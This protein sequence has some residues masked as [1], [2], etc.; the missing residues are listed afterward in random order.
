MADYNISLGVVVETGNIQ[1]Q[2]N[3]IGRNLTPIEID[4]RLNDG[5]ILNQI[6]NIR[7]QLQEL[8]NIRINI[9]AGNIGGIGNIG[10]VGNVARNINNS[11]SQITTSANNASNTIQRLRQ[12]LAS[13][14]F[15]N[16]SINMVTQHLEQMSLAITNV[17]SRI[18]NNDLRLNI[19][20][21]D[22]LGRTVTIL[23]QV[24]LAT[25]E[26]TNIGKNI[27]QSFGRS[28][29]EASQIN[30]A[31]REMKSLIGQISNTQIETNK[32]RAA[33]Q[34]VGALEIK[35]AAL[36]ARY[37]ELEANFAGGFDHN[38]TRNI[39]NEWE[40]VSHNINVA[41]EAITNVRSNLANGVRINFGNYDNQIILLENRFNALANK[42][43][44]VRTA[45]DSV[46]QALTTLR[47]ADGNENVIAAYDRYIEVLRT[48]QT[49]LAKLELI[50]RGSN[51]SDQFVAAK[52]AAMRR[53]NSLF[54]E[55]S[56]AAKKYGAYAQQLRRE[57]ENCGN[58]QGVQNVT[59]KIN[60]LGTEIKNTNIQTQTLGERLKN[61][62]SKYSSY[63][64][65]ATVVMMSMRALR[66][67]FNQVKAIDTAMTELKKVTNE[68]D[69]SYNKFLRNAS[70][71]AKE[72]GTTID[73]LVGS[74]ADFARLGYSFKESQG[75][76]EV[77]NIYAVVGDEVEG[78]E[79]ATE[80]LIS[81]MAAFKGEMDGMSDS[82]FAMNII[83]K[84]NEVGKL[85]A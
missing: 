66:D 74:T 77:A 53:L 78:V 30:A 69:A 47:S 45:I 50:E 33:G 1:T 26:I 11:M 34:E 29:E 23:K 13:A 56:A 15:D 37:D 21:I 14:R 10:N 76:A 55:G 25:G 31:Y 28:R 36:N 79:G 32:L 46:R 16:A 71:R 12:T 22:E 5:N 6:A 9:G 72:I 41:N 52:E 27:S 70:S 67:M 59:R 49:E 3:G 64:S 65:V 73:G 68:T 57:L 82:D 81:T 51:K 62:F 17:T 58:I 4:A 85:I 48:A 2:I 54:S 7:R 75:L 8:S 42:T 38:Q 44:E 83:D 20:G 18:R 60:A 39:T 63:F 40:R 84:F 43:P 80:S 35:L 24:N 19:T 61:Q